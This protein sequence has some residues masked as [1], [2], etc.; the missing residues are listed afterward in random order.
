[1]V[2]RKNMITHLLLLNRLH[3]KQYNKEAV[4][5]PTQLENKDDIIYYFDT[6]FN[7]KENYYIPKSKDL[8][9]D[10]ADFKKIAPKKYTYKKEK[11][12][13]EKETMKETKKE[14]KKEIP[15]MSEADKADKRKRI[16]NLLSLSRA[17]KAVTPQ[18][19]KAERQKKLKSLLET[20]RNI[21]QVQEE[22]KNKMSNIY[23]KLLSERM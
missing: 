20:T 5:A 10:E 23:S 22:K 15:S 8:K 4:K 18:D 16:Q 11:M 9:Y 17:M 13:N 19:I 7:K 6:L 14:T 21:K 3:R 1:M 2:P 12:S